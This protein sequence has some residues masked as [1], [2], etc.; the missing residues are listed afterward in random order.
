MGFIFKIT[1]M[2][3]LLLKKDGSL[4][5]AKEF[6]NKEKESWDASESEVSEHAWHY[7]NDV[8]KFEN[9]ITLKDFF[10]LINKNIDIFV[11]IF[12][13][14]IDDYTDVIL[15]GLPESRK[16]DD[17]PIDYLHVRWR[18]DIDDKEK[19]LCIPAFPD[20]GGVGVATHD[21]EYYKKGEIIYWAIGYSPMQNYADLP[22]KLEEIVDVW[23]PEQKEL[24]KYKSYDYTLYQV[25]QGIIWEISFHGAPNDTYKVMQELREQMER[26]DSGEEKTYLFEDWITKRNLENPE[27]SA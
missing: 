15:N 19:E 4:I 6:Y 10:N 11:G 24:K 7:L 14:W 8:I 25:I 17:Q 2:A 23:Y 20:F 22:L 13:N 3:T 5:R 21:D 26:I 16:E 18:L 12:G 27:D 1:K 9:G